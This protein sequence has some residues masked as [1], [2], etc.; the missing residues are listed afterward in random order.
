M[1]D[2]KQVIGTDPQNYC[3]EIYARRP[4]WVTG[5]ISHFDAR[6]LFSRAL[7]SHAAVAVEVGTASGVSTAFLCHALEV[8]ART[9]PGSGDFR[10]YTYDISP[11]FFADRDKETGA[12]TRTL[13]TPQ[14]L[15]HVVFRNPATA[16]NVRH[17]HRPDSIEFM[18]LDASH[19][20]PW[21]TLDLLAVL[22][23][24][25]PGAEIVVHDI[26][27]P[28]R[29]AKAHDWGVKHVFDNLDVEKRTDG[30]DAIPNVGSIVVPSDKE[31]LRRQLLGILY[32]H[33]WETDVSA[34]D[35]TVALL[36]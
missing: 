30:G 11:R 19:Q 28:L 4:D 21:P 1:T 32:A 5:T 27:L 10:V 17:D 24:M 6:F 7:A 2:W 26:N 29:S 3:D 15:E 33:K 23:S 35:T 22:D 18:F 36:A 12:A 9:A 31:D 25:R 13:L 8:V 14:L 34:D 20:H 16:A